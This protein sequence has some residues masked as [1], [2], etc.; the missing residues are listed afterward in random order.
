MAGAC[1]D[2]SSGLQSRLS[3]SAAAATSY[4]F[5]VTSYTSSGGTLAFQ[6][7]FQTSAGNPTP[8]ATVRP[9]TPTNTPRFSFTA[10]ATRTLP[11][12]TATLTPSPQ[13]T[14]R[15]GAPTNDDCSSALLIPGVP[16]A[17]TVTTTAATAQATDP[18]PTC[19]NRSRAKSVWYAFTAPASVRL[20]ANTFG[21]SYDTILA[22][23]TGACG[24]L[25]Q[26]PGACNDDASGLQSR[27]SFLAQAGTT[28]HLLA[29]AYRGDGGRLVFQLTE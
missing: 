29:T 9:P 26:V 21:S 15:L 13:A 8:T 16:Y 17:H 23:Y 1:N 19:G 24:N 10:T 4:Y 25:S 3:L 28:Y 7:T 12:P 22:V 18:A 2:D 6:L 27:V 14:P 5:L 20:T 11:P